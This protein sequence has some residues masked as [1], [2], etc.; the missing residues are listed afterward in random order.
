MYKF[1]SDGGDNYDHR[2]F[3]PD[4]TPS[5]AVDPGDVAQ[6]PGSNYDYL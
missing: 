3:S 5:A 1:E 4:L 6:G 2:L